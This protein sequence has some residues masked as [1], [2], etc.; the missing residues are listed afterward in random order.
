MTPA[1][2]PNRRFGSVA[3]TNVSDP[4]IAESVVP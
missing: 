2:G 4:A 1:S 3:A